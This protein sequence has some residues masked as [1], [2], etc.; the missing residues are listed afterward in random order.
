MTFNNN[1]IILFLFLSVAISIPF[2]EF[3][4][5]NL[6]SINERTDLK[7][8]FLTV[9]R[10]ISLYLIFISLS[11]IAVYILDKFTKLKKFEAIIIF[12]FIYWIIFKYNE[13][14]KIFYLESL[15]DYDGYLSLG[16]SLIII[17]IFVKFYLRRK[18]N[19]INIFFSFFFII[20]FI[21]FF[22]NIILFKN[23]NQ[24]NS[25]KNFNFEKV[26]ISS[27]ERN[28]IYLIIVDAMPPIEIA[29]EILGTESDDF[30]KKIETNN[31]RYIKDS[32]SFYGNTFHTLGSIFNLKKLE[33][34]NGKL[35]YP[36]LTFPSLMR[37]KNQTNLEFNLE[38]LGYE[39]KWI[40]SHFANCYGYNM[41]YCINEI[42]SSNILF[43]YEIL[44]FLKKTSLKPI[45]STIFNI[46][47]I[48]IEEK[49][50]FK[51]NNGIGNF[52]RYLIDNGK[53]KNPTFILIHHLVSHWP[54]LVD[55]K[56][57]YEKTFGKINK[58]GIKKAFEC[59]KKLISD[60]SDIISQVDNEA[61]VVIQSDH[62]W[63][64]SYE[65]PKIYGERR[66]IFNLVKTNEFCKKYE[67]YANNNLNTIK[68]SL[69][70]ATNTEP[71]FLY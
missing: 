67:S 70:C 21:F 29:D 24:T 10:L 1:K 35:K 61:I 30:I 51:S 33:T 47:D 20:N 62:N 11:I 44:S 12:T 36:S 37:E 60:I 16:L 53:P 13:I 27:P 52:K 8:N 4:N 25:I 6:T 31:F 9:K 23:A 43:N 2:L 22:L 39:I 58:D 56:C 46:F 17:I 48:S 5:Y 64:L 40:G 66:S 34:I 15:N 50:I 7:I 26:N 69:Y 59:N 42:S 65:D 54:Y 45:L 68:L 19:F 32:K 28:N 38:N 3:F 57:N 55:S 71:N 63:E 14:K 41:R 49:I 18:T